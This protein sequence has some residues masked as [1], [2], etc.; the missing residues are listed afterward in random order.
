MRKE[1]NV[2]P[3]F[4]QN[5]QDASRK[6]AQ[7]CKRRRRRSAVPAENFP[8][9]QVRRS[10]WLGR[11]AGTSTLQGGSGMLRE[12]KMRNQV[13]GT[14]SN[15]PCTHTNDWLQI[16]NTDSLKRCTRTKYPQNMRAGCAPRTCACDIRGLHIQVCE[17]AWQEGYASIIEFAT[18]Q[19]QLAERQQV[20][21]T[22]AKVPRATLL[23]TG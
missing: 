7:N 15:T 18:D 9:T 8:G 13:R 17:R 11:R 19:A 6:E 3:R 10:G 2:R 14:N 21:E 23:Q 20:R 16:A 4:G 1:A 5:A 22:T 12:K